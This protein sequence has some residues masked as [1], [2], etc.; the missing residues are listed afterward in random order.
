MACRSVE[1]AERE[2]KRLGFDKSKYTVMELELGS[3]ENVR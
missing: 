3:L 1:K 2:A